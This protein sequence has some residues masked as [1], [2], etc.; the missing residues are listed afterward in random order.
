MPAFT[1]TVNRINRDAEDSRV[2]EEAWGE[3][4]GQGQ[5]DE[6]VVM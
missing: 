6:G 5:R 4:P 2:G 1:D 3:T